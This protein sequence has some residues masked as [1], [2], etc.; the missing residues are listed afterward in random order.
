LQ[1]II[2]NRVFDEKLSVRDT[3]KLIRSIT[4]PKSPRKESKEEVAL[5]AIYSDVEERFKEIF[6]TK[7]TINRKSKKKGKIEIEYYSDEELERLIELIN[8]IKEG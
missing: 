3:E 1:Y 2:A 8:S 5:T 6:G 7:V 4:R